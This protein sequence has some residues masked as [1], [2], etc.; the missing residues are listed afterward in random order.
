MFGRKIKDLRKEL[1]LTQAQAAEITGFPQS[2]ISGIE[3][4]EFPSLEYIY[5]LCEYAEMDISEFFSDKSA[6]AEKYDIPEEYILLIQ[7]LMETPEEFRIK[8]LNMITEFTE[9]WLEKKD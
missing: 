1:N 3:K 4:S 7:K 6:L 8:M 9:M 2:S 5:R